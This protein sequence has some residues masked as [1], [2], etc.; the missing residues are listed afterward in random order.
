MKALITGCHGQVGTELMALAGS[1]G[2][3][4]MGFGHDKLDI[5]DEKSVQACMQAVQPDVVIN[6][7]AYTGVDKAE[8][9]EET[10][11]AV[12]ATGVVH[13]AK[14]CAQ[15]GI[16]LVH[17]STDYV[18]D[19]SQETAYVEDDTVSPLGVYGKTK[20]EGEKTVQS[21]CSKYYIF[22]TSW[23]FSAHGNNFVKTMLR[24]GA[25]REILGV[26][27]DQL[28]KPTSA[29]EIARVIYEV[30]TSKQ[31]AWGVYH[32][33]QSDVT[34]W[35]GFAT[36]IFAE[37]K[38][39]GINLNIKKVNPITTAGYPTPAPR[40]Q[41]SELNCRKIMKEFGITPTLWKGDL[42]LV[43]KSICH[44]EE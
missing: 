27:A 31:E 9:D 33:A 6:A 22:R 28:G 30:L 26:V 38:R 23:V 37:A 36:S 25:E 3:E 17:I 44:A 2:V 7:A 20:L 13:L 39:Q 24:L 41:N 11:K 40:P 5:T 34:S 18:F 4:A 32:L 8:K 21:L 14:E 42:A 12:N 19:G 1:Y 35:H 29:R 43:V 10:A 15:V 16:P